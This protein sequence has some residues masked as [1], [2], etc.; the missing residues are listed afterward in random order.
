MVDRVVEE[1]INDAVAEAE[2]APM[3]DPGG[4]ASRVY[5]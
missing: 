5:A 1:E 3:P 2:A 4:V